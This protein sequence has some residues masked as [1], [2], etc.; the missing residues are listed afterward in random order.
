MDGTVCSC[1]HSQRSDVRAHHATRSLQLGRTAPHTCGAVCVDERHTRQPP[2]HSYL[3]QMLYRCAALSR[4]AV[5]KLC[6]GDERRADRRSR[7]AN[8]T[9]VSYFG[10]GLLAMS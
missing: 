4:V 1:M 6:D 8:L 5:P 2:R 10:P 3:V 9:A 7:A